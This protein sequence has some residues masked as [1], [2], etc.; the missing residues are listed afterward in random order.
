MGRFCT[1][2]VLTLLASSYAKMSVF[3][4]ILIFK[5]VSL[6]IFNAQLVNS[7]QKLVKKSFVSFCAL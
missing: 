1:R 6:A 2:G 3:F 5:L 7:I 4:A